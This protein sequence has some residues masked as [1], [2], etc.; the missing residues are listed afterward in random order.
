MTYVAA[1]LLLVV[2]FWVSLSNFKPETTI[3]Q[4]KPEV[5][6]VAPAPKFKIKKREH[7]P[8]SAI[9]PEVQRRLA[10]AGLKTDSFIAVATK[11]QEKTNT[12]N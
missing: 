8:V 9:S 7:A 10:A 3:K 12:E 1:F 4:L 6:Q 2:A 11:K 5:T